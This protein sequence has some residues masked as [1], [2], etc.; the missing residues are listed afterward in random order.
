M[1]AVLSPLLIIEWEDSGKF[2][3]GCHKG[4]IPREVWMQFPG[5]YHFPKGEGHFQ[6][7]WEDNPSHPNP[8]P[9]NFNSY[10]VLPYA[11]SQSKL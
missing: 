9:T 5:S 8:K 11:A 7:P 4:Y 3:K 2:L 1:K 10:L 6:F